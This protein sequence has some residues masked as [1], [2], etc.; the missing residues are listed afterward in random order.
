MI[1]IHN[2]HCKWRIELAKKISSKIVKMEDVEAIAIGGSVARGY[3]DEYSD[4]EILILWGELPSEETR[5]HL[6]SKLCAECLYPFNYDANEDNLIIEGIQVDLWH[7]TVS[8]ESEVIKSILK[9]EDMS[10]G[11]SNFMDTISM[12]IPIYGESII[13]KWKE[14]ASRYPY[15]YAIYNIEDSL[16]FLKP[17]HLELHM[18]R[19]NPTL[20]FNNIIELQKRMFLLLLALNERYFPTYKWMYVSLKEMRNKPQNIA[21]RFQEVFRLPCKEA[22]EVTFQHIYEVIEL[23]NQLHPEVE[24][25]LATK[26]LVGTRKKLIPRIVD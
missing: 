10:L 17:G 14:D 12:C 19:N 11:N 25:E 13:T 7:N 16:R 3:A 24:T 5:K 2:E 4:I 9:S 8:C 22:I 6:I 1:E 18:Y 26:S 15:E 21:E 23:I 20:V